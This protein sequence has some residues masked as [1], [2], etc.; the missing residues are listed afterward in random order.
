MAHDAP[1][2]LLRFALR[3][4]DLPLARALTRAI[5]PRADGELRAAARFRPGGAH[6]GALLRSALDLLATG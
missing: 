5:G 3:V 4:G 1:L 6:P 2:A